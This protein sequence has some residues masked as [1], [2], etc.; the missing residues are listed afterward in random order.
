[1]WGCSNNLYT[2]LQLKALQQEP[3]QRVCGIPIAP[4]ERKGQLNLPPGEIF[5]LLEKG[6]DPWKEALQQKGGNVNAAAVAASAAAAAA[7]P[8]KTIKTVPRTVKAG[9]EGKK[10]R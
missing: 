1:V 3:I 10:R 7:S 8:G 4:K 9:F 5:Q 2:S 6:R